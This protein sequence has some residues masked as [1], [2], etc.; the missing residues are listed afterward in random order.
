MRIRW[1]GLVA[2]GVALAGAAAVQ[3]QK[4]DDFDPCTSNDMCSN[5]ECMG[6]PGGSGSCDDGNDC[7]IN[8]RCDAF[9]GC[10]GDP[11]P[12]GT[13]CAGGCGTCQALFPGAPATCGGKLADNGKA[14]DAGYGPCIDGSCFIQG[15][16]GFTIAFCFPAPKECPDAGNC[17]GACNPNTG[18]CDNNLL[19]CFGD[20][21][22]CQQG[23]CAPANQGKACDDSDPCTAQSKCGSFEVGGALR[24]VCIEGAPSGDTPTP[25]VTGGAATATVPPTATATIGPPTATRTAATPPTPG[26]CVGDCNHDGTIAV[27]ELI[28]GV[29]I[30]LGNSDVSTCRSFDT[31]GDGSVAV[32]ELIAGVN[33]ALNGCAA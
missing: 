25:T 21:E 4:C 11:A 22:S 20:C 17:K 26:P 29:N 14:C 6:T 5:G 23:Q 10:T 27:N 28:T 9:L 33:A 2:M 3:A 13:S 8:D 24:G 1:I 12:N 15:A 32:N 19:R 31:N 7:T 16:G 18:R 30:A